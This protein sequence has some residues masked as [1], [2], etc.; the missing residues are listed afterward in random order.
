MLYLKSFGWMAL[1][2]RACVTAIALPQDTHTSS[3]SS[4]GIAVDTLK[5][6]MTASDYG[7]P[8]PSRFTGQASLSSDIA[9]REGLS[10]TFFATVNGKVAAIIPT[11]VPNIVSTAAYSTGQPPPE[12]IDKAYGTSCF[13]VTFPTSATTFASRPPID[14]RYTRRDD[15][16]NGA[17][18][19]GR[20]PKTA[21][22]MAW[23]IGGVEEEGEIL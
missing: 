4:E 14:V 23:C 19:V 12:T 16:P 8:V 18:V 20:E 2:L 13:T 11:P 5:H 10:S 9:A 22:V 7:S 21:S 3:V 15:F 17:D 1:A 6:P